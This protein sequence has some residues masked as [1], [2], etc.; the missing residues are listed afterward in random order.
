[1]KEKR[2]ATRPLGPVCVFMSLIIY[3]LLQILFLIKVIASK[4]GVGWFFVP[5]IFIFPIVYLLFGKCMNFIYISDRGVRHKKILYAWE[6]VCITMVYMSIFDMRGYRYVLFF[7]H[8][9]ISKEEAKFRPVK[10]EGFYLIATKKNLKALFEFYE[11]RVLI[12]E[13]ESMGLSKGIKGLVQMHNS[14]VS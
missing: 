10:K 6:D 4:D 8:R 5:W 1:M 13:K 2:L 3:L 12:L 11:K 9:Y 14:R 7:K